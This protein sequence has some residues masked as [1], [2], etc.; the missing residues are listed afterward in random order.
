[1]IT[2][3]MWQAI[4]QR[5]FGSAYNHPHA[6]GHQRRNAPRKLTRALARE[7]K[8]LLGV[9]PQKTLATRFG[10][11]NSMVTRIAKGEIYRE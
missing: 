4:Q 9:V 3:S 7:L 11:S 10:I 2:D 6:Y 1:M 5:N 8:S